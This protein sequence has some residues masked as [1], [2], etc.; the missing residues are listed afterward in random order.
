VHVSPQEPPRFSP[1]LPLPPE[2]LL[3]PPELPAPPELEVPPA[4]PP[5]P[6]E[7][8]VPLL[9][10]PEL[11]V[12]PEGG[13]SPSPGQSKPFVHVA[14]GLSHALMGINRSAAVLSPS[15]PKVFL[16]S[17]SPSSSKTS[18]DSEIGASFTHL[19]DWSKG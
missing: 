15:K 7:A 19:N 17:F 8:P 4:S 14:N 13:P 11:E 10:P 12:P 9:L 1:P 18:A 5:E 6:S 2:G 16:I 3:L